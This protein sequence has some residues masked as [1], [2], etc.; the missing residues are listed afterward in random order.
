MDSTFIGAAA[1][2]RRG[3]ALTDLRASA[4]LVAATFII[5]VA[6]YWHG[7][8]PGD[9]ERY[10]RAALLW[11]EKGFYL[12]DTHW[13]LRHL[14][15][16]PLAASFA[17][18]GVSEFSATLPNIVYAG[19]LV[20]MTFYFVRRYIGEAEAAIGAAFI[21]TSSFFVARPIEVEAYGAEI[22]FDA[23][24]CWLFI[25][26]GIERRRYALLL[27]AGVSAGF[28]WTIREQT[29]YLMLVFG[30]LV[31]WSRKDIWRSG[32]AL[33]AGFGAV[34][35]VE[36]I[37]YAI[38]AGDPFYRYKIDINHR[39]IGQVVV[40]GAEES[41]LAKKLTRPIKDLLVSP[42]TTPFLILASFAALR[43]GWRAAIETLSRRRTLLVFCAMS[44]AA[45]PICA[46][47]FNLS[48]PR[49]YP[50]LTYAIFLFLAVMTTATA[51][52]YGA[53]VAAAFA[54]VIT[55]LNAAAADFSRYQEYSEARF[56]AEAT[57]RYDE[58]IESDPLT[59]SRARYQLVL[60]GV[61][62]GE[63]SKRI[64]MTR[65]P[66]IGAL[67]YK[68][69]MVRRSPANWCRIEIVDIRPRNWTHALIRG[70]GLDR[71]A[72]AKIGSI[73]ARPAPVEIVRVLAGPSEVDPVTG[74]PCRN[75][76]KKEERGRLSAPRS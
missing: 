12:G 41:T 63:A 7:F 42:N 59:A 40:I 3:S 62:L 20:A 32:L 28:A 31:L 45:I 55:L 50:I 75:Q 13:A 23:L 38:A 68:S 22:L 9:P 34:I 56:L 73:V 61:S 27:A 74:A 48:L 25:A 65:T 60:R 17:A 21:A 16:L 54:V 44:A 49:Y 10:V 58:P 4:I 64:H 53:P 57:A 39:L 15:V 30:L 11:V 47:A 5:S 26:A 35:A 69:E 1:P 18:I 2:K 6:A 72:G 37:F 19:A 36:W 43:P 67:Y 14:F 24:A 33:G 66:T 51:R 70:S 71:I 29:L 52:R 46:Y 8:G 76:P